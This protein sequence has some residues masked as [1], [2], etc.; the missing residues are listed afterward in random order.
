MRKIWID[1]IT[2]CYFSEPLCRFV[3]V[4][5]IKENGVWKFECLF[6]N[7]REEMEQAHE[8]S[9]IDYKD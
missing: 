8:G 4:A 7:S 3:V 6:F 2:D 5:R 9:V 1:R